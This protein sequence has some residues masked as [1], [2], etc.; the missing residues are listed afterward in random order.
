MRTAS[1]TLESIG[2]RYD[3]SNGWAIKGVTLELYPRE[4]TALSGPSGSGKTTLLSILG[5]IL[6]PSEGI[7]NL[8]QQN[9]G[10]FD[11]QQ[12]QQFRRQHIGL[13]FQSCNLLSSLTALENIQL[14]L[15][16]RNAGED[17]LDLLTSV[18]LAEKADSYPAQLS[19]GQRQRVAIARAFAGNP[20]LLL[21]DEPTA[22]LDAVQGRGVME[23][24]RYRAQENGAT[25]IVVTHD[26]RMIRYADR[27]IELEDG[28]VTRRY[29]LLKESHAKPAVSQPAVPVRNALR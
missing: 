13:V 16:M 17:A 7:L 26:P 8:L 20:D 9:A 5:C 22:A 12:R 15:S 18:G 23:L 1:I 21:A 24:L 10:Q 27:V 2:K 6:S 28:A 29:R 14:A 3:D 19:G 4:V 11:E 25:V